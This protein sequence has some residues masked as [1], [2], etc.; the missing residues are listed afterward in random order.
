MQ[1]RD[2]ITSIDKYF[3]RELQIEITHAGI[4]A[5]E[6]LLMITKSRRRLRQTHQIVNK[7]ETA[8]RRE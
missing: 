3:S 5:R 6:T 8:E 7:E 2:H 4:K 1:V